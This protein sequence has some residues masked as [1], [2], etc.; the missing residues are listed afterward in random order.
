VVRILSVTGGLADLD[1]TGAGVLADATALAAL[2]ITSD[3]RQNLAALY[4]VGAEPVAGA[5]AAFYILGF[6]LVG[7]AA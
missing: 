2:G 1:V 4:T 3:E 5:A 6:Q 7:G